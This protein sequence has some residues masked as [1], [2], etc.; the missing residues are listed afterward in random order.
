M[1]KSQQKIIFYQYVYA[2]MDNYNRILLYMA[3][4]SAVRD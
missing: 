2:F 3:L 4:L 1:N